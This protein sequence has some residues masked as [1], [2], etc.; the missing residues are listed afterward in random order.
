VNAQVNAG[1]PGVDCSLRAVAQEVAP[2]T[3]GAVTLSN[4]TTVQYLLVNPVP[5]KQGSV[6]Q[7]TVE[8]PG[9]IRFDA[10]LGKTF[11][12]SESKSVQIRFDATNVLNHPNPPDPTFSIN[13]EDFGYLVGNKTGNRSFQGQLRLNF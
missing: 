6:G 5:G 11:R 13:S 8:G 2:G 3:P 9:T 10:N 4:G 1:A 7:T 12:I